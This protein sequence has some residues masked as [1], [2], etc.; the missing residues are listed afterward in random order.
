MLRAMIVLLVPVF[1]I[2]G[3]YHI[4]GNDTPPTVDTSSAYD[5]ARAA[6]QFEVLTPQGLSGDWRISSAVYRSGTLRLGVN[7]PHN[8][9][10]QVVE[11]STPAMTSVPAEVGAS[12][13]PDGSAQLNGATWQRFTG[14]R[15]DEKALVLSSSNRTVIVVG[16]AGDDD[17]RALA[18]ALRP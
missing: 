3:L 13:R 9:A 1:L 15:P 14:G 11:T 10:L 4:L 6:K 2:V 17:L 16:K 5:A 7:A 12:A 18:A 8:G